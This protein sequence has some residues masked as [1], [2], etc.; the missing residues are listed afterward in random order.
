MNTFSHQ[1]KPTTNNKNIMVFNSLKT[2]ITN[3][4]RNISYKGKEEDFI[5]DPHTSPMY[6]QLLSLYQEGIAFYH[7][8]PFIRKTGYMDASLL[9]RNLREL[10]YNV[11]KRALFRKRKTIDP[12]FKCIDFSM[13]I[14]GETGFITGNPDVDTEFWKMASTMLTIEIDGEIKIFPRIGVFNEI[15]KLERKLHIKRAYKLSFTQK[16]S[17]YI[18][19]EG[20]LNYGDWLTLRGLGINVK[21]NNPYIDLS[22]GDLYWDGGN[23]SSNTT[24]KILSTKLKAKINPKDIKYLYGECEYELV[25]DPERNLTFMVITNPKG[26]V[27]TAY[28]YQECIK[29]LDL[30]IE[31]DFS[32]KFETFYKNAEILPTREKDMTDINGNIGKHLEGKE[33]PEIKRIPFQFTGKTNKII[34]NGSKNLKHKLI[35][36]I[37]TPLDKN[38]L[39]P[40]LLASHNKPAQ[41][42]MLSTG[43]R[44]NPG[45]LEIWETKVPKFKNKLTIFE[46]IS[47]SNYLI[48]RKYE[49]YNP[50]FT[51]YLEFFQGRKISNS[52]MVD[53]ITAIQKMKSNQ[54]VRLRAMTPREKF[55][56]MGMK[57]KDIE[58]LL[59]SGLSARKLS[60]LAGNSVV[61]NVWEAIMKQ[62]L[63]HESRENNKRLAA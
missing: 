52:G 20:I 32:S 17:G 47:Q 39:C 33:I 6:C 2:E 30:Y 4:L 61:V 35:K 1:N 31:M 37:L 49:G 51:K 41:F 16:P 50:K 28:H 58:K 55:R 59:K 42:N 21:V 48:I 29:G 15:Q 56:L 34:M 3:P 5:T 54:Y 36:Q 60:R 24:C 9:S 14:K 13:L 57:E 11:G 45:V 26:R 43:H 40:T 7:N 8:T 46:K 53:I 22:N 27:I 23:I 44:P 19:A 63:L 62:I 25:A 18:L 38:G 10:T 12:A